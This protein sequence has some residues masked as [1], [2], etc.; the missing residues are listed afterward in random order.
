VDAGGKGA[1]MAEVEAAGGQISVVA[2]RHGISK[3]LL[4]NWRSAWKVAGLT[5]RAS[6]VPPA[7]FVQLG[8]VA[9]ASGQGP[10]MPITSGAVSPR[11]AVSKPP[12]NRASSLQ[13][14]RHTGALRRGF[15]VVRSP[16][17][18]LTLLG[19]FCYV[20]GLSRRLARRRRR[21][22]ILRLFL[23]GFLVLLSHKIRDRVFSIACNR[24]M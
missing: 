8:V 21:T 18:H 16:S 19:Y 1:L 24:K 11:S 23:N 20:A 10:M 22:G 9:D 13:Y 6:A 7:E 2:Q 15:E 4:Y 14:A 12:F 5:A 3:S 17:K